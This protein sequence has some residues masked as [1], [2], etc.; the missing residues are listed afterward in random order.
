[1]RR[2]LLPLNVGHGPALDVGAANVR[3]ER[4][5]ALDVDAFPVTPDQVAWMDS[6]TSARVARR[7]GMIADT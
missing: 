5:V 6:S 3:T 7:A 4:F 1:M 2:V